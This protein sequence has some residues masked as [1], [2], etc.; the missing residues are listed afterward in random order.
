MKMGSMV[1]EEEVYCG[2][3]DRRGGMRRGKEKEGNMNEDGEERRL[4]RIE[5][6]RSKSKEKRGAGMNEREEQI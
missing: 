5:R 4:K 2:R 3:R 6:V 1:I